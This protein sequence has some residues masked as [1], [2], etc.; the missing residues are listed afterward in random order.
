MA[1]IEPKGVLFSAGAGTALTGIALAGKT[2]PR[3]WLPTAVG[4]GVASAG[5]YVTARAT[6]KPILAVPIGIVGGP[7]ALAGT[8]LLSGARGSRSQWI[9]TAV[10]GGMLGGL[11]GMIAAT[12]AAKA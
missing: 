8:L 4:I 9:A 7:A 3:V 5:G 12:Q 1:S 6:D 2:Q 11:S 10:V